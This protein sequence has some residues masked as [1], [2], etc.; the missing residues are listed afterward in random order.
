M[1]WPTHEAGDKPSCNMHV[2][3]VSGRELAFR[4]V[5]L[6]LM[7]V[8]PASV[9]PLALV[10]CG[11]FLPAI[12]QERIETLS[13][14]W[15]FPFC[16]SKL[17]LWCAAVVQLAT[18][19]VLA[20]RERTQA[21]WAARA[22]AWRPISQ[23]VRHYVV[24]VRRIHVAV[25]G[26]FA[27]ILLISACVDPRESRYIPPFGLA[28][29]A[30]QFSSAIVMGAAAVADRAARHTSVALLLAPSRYINWALQI[31][32]A[33]LAAPHEFP[34]FT[35]AMG[36]EALR[37]ANGM[38]VGLVGMK[39]YARNF[40]GLDPSVVPHASA[41]VET[42]AL[43]RVSWRGEPVLYGRWIRAPQLLQGVFIGAEYFAT[44]RTLLYRVPTAVPSAA[45][46][47]AAPGSG[48]LS[49]EH[50]TRE[51]VFKARREPNCPLLD[52]PSVSKHGLLS[53]CISSHSISTKFNRCGDTP[54]TPAD[55]VHTTWVR[56]PRRIR[57]RVYEPC[58]HGEDVV[59]DMRD[60]PGKWRIRTQSVETTISEL[61]LPVRVPGAMRELAAIDGTQLVGVK[62]CVAKAYTRET[63]EWLWESADVGE[64]LI[65][66]CIV[67]LSLTACLRTSVIPSI[68]ITVLPVYDPR[69]ISCYRLSLIRGCP[70]KT[71][72]CA[73]FCCNVWH[74]Y[75]IDTTKRGSVRDKSIT[76]S[77]RQLGSTIRLGSMCCGC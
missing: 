17:G 66:V 6:C 13:L 4:A 49:E 23:T 70:R 77:M 3:V 47:S 30:V 11:P 34:L 28:F 67:K 40:Y 38:I 8:L 25:F 5:W 21:I 27:I 41:L 37:V 51:S 2:E 39:S 33:V 24:W 1:L 60:A 50:G 69:S 64:L 63:T 45:I 20:A 71:V 42:I 55:K 53:A 19:S 74:V 52:V 61:K 22:D 16:L 10:T 26:S 18:L 29:V 43:L 46:L 36:A 57:V 7:N 12:P 73:S 59:V 32:E 14:P 54:P 48:I 75:P 9:H 35:L 76:W 15:L 68:S 65:Q 56:E 44:K 58:E 62:R 31:R 72:C